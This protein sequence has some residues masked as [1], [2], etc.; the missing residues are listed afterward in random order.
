MKIRS[1]RTLLA[2]LAALLIVTAGCGSGGEAADGEGLTTV[3]IGTLRALSD[4]PVYI[5]MAQGYFED[6]GLDVENTNFKNG[7]EMVAPLASG[8]LQVAAGAPSAGL[9][10]ALSSGLD[11]TIVA[12]KGHV[13][14]DS[15]FVAFLARTDLAPQLSDFSSLEGL[16]VGLSAPNASNF[17]QLARAL[18]SVGLT[19]DDV[20]IS[21][22]DFPSMGTALANGSIDVAL[23]P[24]PFVASFVAQDLA[25]RWKGVEEA[26][27]GQQAG[28]V[29]FNGDFAG[30]DEGE[31]GTAFMRA[32]LRAIADYRQAFFGDGANRDEIVEILTESTSVSEASMYDAIVPAGLREDGLVDTESLAA[33]AATYD[34]AGL[35]EGDFTAADFVDNS[36]VE[37]A[38][39]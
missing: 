36:F 13:G 28:V 20:T 31:Q 7:A 23:A 18:G 32:Y 2:G 14:P 3:K 27:P 15:D 10:N 4:A 38:A 11:I 29:M 21:Q 30:A 8:Q 33:D 35:L 24:E 34:E 22:L 26:V 9:F 39:E 1:T 5:A 25:T 37:G 19:T 12:D 17:V 16:T 6:E